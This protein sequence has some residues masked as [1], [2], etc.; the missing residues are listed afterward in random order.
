MELVVFQSRF[1]M[2]EDGGPAAARLFQFRRIASVFCHHHAPAGHTLGVQCAAGYRVAD[3]A[4]RFVSVRAI[5]KPAK[6]GELGDFCE[7]L[8]NTRGGVTDMERPHSR[9]IDYPATARHR[10]KRA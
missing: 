9:R 3:R 4:A 7:Q 8:I 2:T 6:R 1:A 10:M 5:A